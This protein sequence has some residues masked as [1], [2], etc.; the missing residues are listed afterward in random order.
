MVYV[1]NPRKKRLV[2]TAGVSEAVAEPKKVAS[3][4]VI[5]GGG[6]AEVKPTPRPLDDYKIS[7]MKLKKFVNLKL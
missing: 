3:S 5:T 1:V 2:A 6:Y 7:Q 4:N